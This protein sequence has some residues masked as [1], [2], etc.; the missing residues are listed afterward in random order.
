MFRTAE[1]FTY[2]ECS[3][4][5]TLQIAEVPHNLGDYYGNS[6][7]SYSIDPLFKK[8]VWRTWPIPLALRLN[9][10]L[11]IAT[12]LG[13]GHRWVTET[14]TQT[15]HRVLELG[16]GGGD[17][18]L[19]MHL[20]GFRHLVGADPYVPEPHEVA[21]GVP[22]WK[23]FHHELD[24]RYD[25]IMMHHSFEHVADPR[26]VLR[27]CRRLLDR[28]GKLLIRMPIMGKAMWREYGTKWVQIDPPRH[29]VLYTTDGFEALAKSEGFEIEK[30]FYDSNEFQFLG[31][32]LVAAARPHAQS[33]RPHNCFP[34]EQLR[35]WKDQAITLNLMED[36]DQGGYVLT[37]A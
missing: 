16:C 19:Q 26:A 3:G 37:A 7:Y 29:L 11:F 35:E 18:L 5:G 15:S 12:G 36:G 1:L 34:P 31:S 23:K 27:S 33:M 4:C 17:V 22:V 9:T 13:R 28:N 8:R 6:Y 32:E 21:P 25:R 24:G 10:F 14:N 20:L 2:R 30:L